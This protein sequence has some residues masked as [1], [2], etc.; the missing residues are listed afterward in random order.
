MQDFQSVEIKAEQMPLNSF[1]NVCYIVS[2]ENDF[3]QGTRA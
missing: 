1:K 2:V 3:Y